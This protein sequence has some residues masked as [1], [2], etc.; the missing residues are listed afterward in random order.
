MTGD[1]VD[2]VE[3]KVG[4]VVVMVLA[5]RLDSTSV[6]DFSARINAHFDAGTN[7]LLMDMAHLAYIT[8]ASFRAL[9]LAHR[10]AKDCGTALALCGLNAIVNELF[11]LTGF[12]DSFEIYPNREA[13]LVA[14]AKA[15]V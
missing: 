4:Q 10:R 8:S 7:A 9:A 12:S 5:G 3:S 14:M 1:A 15:T 6:R 2:I 13:G 11:D